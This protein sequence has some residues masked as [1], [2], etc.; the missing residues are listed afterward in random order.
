MLQVLTEATEVW[1]STPDLLALEDRVSF[2]EIDFFQAG[3]KTCLTPPAQLVPFISN[4]Q[5]FYQ[6]FFSS[7]FSQINELG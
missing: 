5:D 3:A 4:C 2:V 1:A 6:A 7:H